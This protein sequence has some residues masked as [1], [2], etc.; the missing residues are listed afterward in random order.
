MLVKKIALLSL[1]GVGLISCSRGGSEQTEASPVASPSPT[2]V[3]LPAPPSLDRV[4][5][6]TDGAM[7]LTLPN[8]WQ[9]EKALHDEAQLQAYD[10]KKE[11]FAIVLAEDRAKLPADLTLEKH[12]DL[13]RGVLVGNL[14]D[15]E[16]TQPT[17]L[18]RVGD[19]PA[20]QYKIAGKIQG[21]DVVYLHTTVE[22]DDRFHQI[23][24]WTAP[25]QFPPNEAELQRIIG[26]FRER[27]S[28]TTE[29]GS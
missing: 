22:T 9:P 3:S 10:P 11:T 21:L 19:Y 8:G 28:T 1:I 14:T 2:P 20:I 29:R 25:P 6:S 23:L 15:P 5:V 16:V 27:Q 17:P 18:I 4:I 12:S 26:S 24:V 13:T 7:Q